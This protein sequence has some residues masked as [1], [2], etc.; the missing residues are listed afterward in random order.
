M[1]LLPSF[2]GCGSFPDLQ[3]G[4]HACLPVGSDAER[5][6]GIAG[7]AGLGLRSGGK[8]AVFTGTETPDEM[9]AYLAAR[10]PGARSALAAGQLGVLDCQD[11]YL[12]GGAFDPAHTV[13]RYIA[14]IELAE[15]QG[16]A[17]LWIVVDMAW[18]LSRLPGTDMLLDYEAEA[19]PG[20]ADHRVAAVCVY[21]RSRFCPVLLEKVCSAHPLTPGQAPLRFARTTDPPGLALSGEVDL[22]NHLAF[23]A[24]LTAL[25]PAPG[26]ITIDATG[27][28]FA[29]LRAADLL[30]AASC[31]RAPGATTITGSPL[32]NRLLELVGNS[33]SAT[34]GQSDA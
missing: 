9:A 27:L 5:L 31:A 33:R 34:G 26:H 7:V 20:F 1:A 16:Y 11:F 15:E 32:V 13:A 29:D 19:N 18:A 3:L 17:G 22:T 8:V 25:Q 24:L 12:A 21:D 14:Q 10:A 23:S 28:R 30:W 2:P 4:D 6:S